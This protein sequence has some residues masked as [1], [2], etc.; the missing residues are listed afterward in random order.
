MCRFADSFGD[1]MAGFSIDFELM[2]SHLAKRQKKVILDRGE[3]TCDVQCVTDWKRFSS[4]NYLF[5][6][7]PC[8]FLN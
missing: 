1:E 4:E 6:F 3:Y 5:M 2:E 7:F 8:H